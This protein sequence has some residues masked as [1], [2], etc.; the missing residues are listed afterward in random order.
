MINGADQLG[1]ASKEVKAECHCWMGLH[2]CTGREGSSLMFRSV[3]QMTVTGGE[4][5][6]V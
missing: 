2:G 6:R 1:A 5:G 4:N 3:G